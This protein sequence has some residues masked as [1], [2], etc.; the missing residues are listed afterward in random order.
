MVTNIGVCSGYDVDDS[1]QLIIAGPGG[2]SLKLPSDPL[3]TESPSTSGR[4]FHPRQTF[5]Q[6]SCILFSSLPKA[7]MIFLRY[8]SGLNR[9]YSAASSVLVFMLVWERN[10]LGTVTETELLGVGK[11][12]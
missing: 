11:L 10:S 5:E 8:S 3:G 9:I 1:I 7:Y 2:P 12:R 4:G 6:I